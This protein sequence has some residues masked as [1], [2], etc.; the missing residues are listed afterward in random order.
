MWFCFLSLNAFSF[1]LFLQVLD[2]VTLGKMLNDSLF[3]QSLAIHQLDQSLLSRSE[4]ET[5]ALNAILLVGWVGTGKSLVAKLIQD[6]FVAQSN[7]HKFSVPLHLSDM[8][9]HYILDDLTEKLEHSCGPSL[10]I[11]EDVD[12]GTLQAQKKLE[13]FVQKLASSPNYKDRRLLIV[14]TMSTGGPTINKN[15]LQWI[16]SST[17]R[18][19]DV[20]INHI[21][22][23]FDLANVEL[24]LESALVEN[25][26]QLTVVPFLPLTREHVTKCLIR[27]MLTQGGGLPSSQD[28]KLIL[29]E[30]EYFSESFPVFAAAGCKRISGKVAFLLASKESLIGVA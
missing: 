30:M 6:S 7:V 25:G 15:M 10:V 2:K 12:D 1:F 11:L 13:E 28:T 16:K 23:V 8:T 4:T 19:E 5:E 26:F 17:L 20:S 3:G 29:D 22:D 9:N 18:R 27:E 24:Q 14:A 21:K